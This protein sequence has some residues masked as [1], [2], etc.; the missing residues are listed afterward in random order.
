L[1]LTASASLG[2]FY[3]RQN[4]LDTEFKEKGAWLAKACIEEARLRLAHDLLFAG[5]V[6]VLVGE[7]MC[8]IGP[9]TDAEGQK[10]FKTRAVYK[11]SYTIFEVSIDTGDF[12]IVSRTE[13]PNF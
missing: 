10:I 4:I 13:V 9:V 1:A 6:E 12:A 11:N 2:G 8:T 5:D 7:D 3:L